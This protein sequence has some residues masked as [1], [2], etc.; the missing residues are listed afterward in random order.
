MIFLQRDEKNYSKPNVAAVL[1]SKVVLPAPNNSDQITVTK[2]NSTS[3]N[4]P[5]A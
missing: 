3:S 4:I 1:I 5:T 2:K